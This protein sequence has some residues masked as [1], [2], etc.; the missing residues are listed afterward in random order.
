MASLKALMSEVSFQEVCSVFV[1]PA[2]NVKDFQP[3]PGGSQV[4]SS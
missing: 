3:G 1:V 4:L 2:H